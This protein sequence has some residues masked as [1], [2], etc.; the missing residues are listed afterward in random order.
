[1]PTQD[2][3]GFEIGPERT[4]WRYMK[5]EHLRSM[6]DTCTLYFASAREFDDSFEGSITCSDFNRMRAVPGMS[7]DLS[8]PG[9]KG[10]IA[11]YELTRLTKANCWHQNDGESLAMWKLYLPNGKG[12]AVGSTVG[13][14]MQSLKEFRLK[15][16]YGAETIYVGQVEYLDYRTGSIPDKSMDGPFFHKRLSYAHEREVRA[17]LSLRMAEEFGVEVPEKGVFVPIDLPMLVQEIR[18]APKLDDTL[19]AD[20]RAM[21]AAAGCS[22]PVHR[23]EMDD[24]AL[25]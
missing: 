16:S 6:L 22:V 12:V 19:L 13:R 9:K 21:V 15:P 20:V 14:L 23:S 3:A 2:R 8:L 4:I 1:M 10:S 25:F 5:L 7:L 24:P 17:V 11:F 18:V